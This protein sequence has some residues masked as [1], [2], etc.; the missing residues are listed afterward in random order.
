MA[1]R[2]GPSWAPAAAAADRSRHARALPRVVR[3]LRGSPA[4]PAA[5]AALGRAAD[6]RRRVPPAADR[7]WDVVQALAGASG[8]RP[9]Q[10]LV[11][12]T[13]KKERRRAPSGQQ[14]RPWTRRPH[15]TVRTRRAAQ[16]RRLVREAALAA[17]E[18]EHAPEHAPAH[19]P[20][21]ESEHEHLDWV[22]GLLDVS[23]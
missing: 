21:H 1:S 9:P 19:A 16:K 13:E 5:N 6:S 10:T 12:L 15:S 23:M 7:V 4:T 3:P 11:Q 8:Q 18:E 22:D 2:L 20:E 17:E 14:A